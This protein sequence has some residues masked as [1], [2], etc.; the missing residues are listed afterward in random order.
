MKN[1]KIISSIQQLGNNDFNEPILIKGGC[2]ATIAY[3]I[4]NKKYLKKNFENVKIDIEQYDSKK[5]INTTKSSKNVLL[6]FNDYLREINNK[7]PPFYY[8]A[9][10]QL[11]NLKNKIHEN[12]ISDI[13]NP[14]YKRVP[15]QNL[16]F[17]GYNK[18]SGCHLHITDD[19]LLNQIIGR[20]IIYL[21]HYENNQLPMNKFYKSQ[22]NFLKD[23]FFSI[24]NKTNCYK[25]ILEAGDSITIPPYWFHATEGIQFN[26]SITNV[27]NR[28]YNHYLYYYPYLLFLKMYNCHINNQNILFF[29]LSVLISIY[30]FITLC[31]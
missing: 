19:F 16:L 17:L 8:C 11:E 22:N 29:I 25:I 27:Y 30:I 14:L 6:H 5:D 12:I 24:K 23:D 31:I 4:W 2:K 3:K 18:R 28:K 1:I 15:D 26:C 20:K 7:K 10:I 21:Y 9:E 13:K